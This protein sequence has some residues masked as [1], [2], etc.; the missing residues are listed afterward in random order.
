MLEAPDVLRRGGS[1]EPPG[2]H[3]GQKD[4]Q[5][6]YCAFHE[7]GP[8]HLSKEIAWHCVFIKR[9]NDALNIDGGMSQVMAGLVKHIF[10]NPLCNVSEVGL[11]LKDDQGQHLR[12]FFELGGFVQD[13]MA[14]KSV[15]PLREML[16]QNT[17]YFAT[18]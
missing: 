18:V 9:S 14:Q 12:L 8:F 17:V 5:V 7:Y 15:F 6:V 4:I 16:V 10:C 2:P 11:L 13:G 3:S 1:R